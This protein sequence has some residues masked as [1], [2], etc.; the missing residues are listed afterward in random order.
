MHKFDT[1]QF[2]KLWESKEGRQ[3]MSTILNDPDMIYSNHTF[4][5]EKFL[6]DPQITPTD[7]L[8]RATFR[9]EMRRIETGSMAHL[10]APLGDSVQREVGNAEFYTGSIP[11]FITDGYL[12]TAKTRL[13]RERLYAQLGND[14]E[15]VQEWVEQVAQPQ[16]DS[17]NQT[18]SNMSAQLMSTGKINYQYGLGIKDKLE[19]ADIPASN[20]KTAGAKV[21]SDTTARL[22][23]QIVTLIKGIKDAT[24]VNIQFQ[25]EITRNM[26]NNNFLNNAQVIE[27]VRYMRSMNN[28]LLPSNIVVTTEMANEALASF[29]GL[30][31]IVIVEESQ[32][33]QTSGIVHGWADTVA[34]LR[35][36]GYAG[37]IRRTNV[38][39]EEVYSKF[40]N[41]AVQFNFSSAVDGLA[42]VMNSVIPNGN[43]KEWHTDTMFSAVPSLDE[44]LYHYIIDTSTADQ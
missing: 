26:W 3:I 10:R 34:V 30:P 4:W 6:I 16:I 12:E 32:K 19:K 17:V 20:F 1:S 29:E 13:Y 42:L 37:Y 39:D 27:W 38:L 9:S 24:G 25:L 28:V 22:L 31:K 35:P 15:L 36:I 2:Y 21:W 44:F 8:G 18:L 5:R 23:D 41:K 11:D 14:R 40:A 33:D 43:L 7:A